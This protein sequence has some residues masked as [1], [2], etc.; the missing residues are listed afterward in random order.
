MVVGGSRHE[1]LDPCFVLLVTRQQDVHV[2]LRELVLHDGL[3]HVLLGFIVRDVITELSGP[4][5]TSCRTEMQSQL[6][7]HCVVI[8]VM[9]VK[10]FLVKIECYRPFCN[11]A[12][13]VLSS[14]LIKFE[15][16]SIIKLGNF[17]F[18]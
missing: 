6:I 4:R 2:T 13:T 8:N 3:H 15:F 7:D 10:S 9:Y 16:I 18:T 11:V 5:P 17:F 14:K 12:T 1:T